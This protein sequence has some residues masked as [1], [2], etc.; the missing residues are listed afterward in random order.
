MT[1]EEIRRKTTGFLNLGFIGLVVSVLL[2][3]KLKFPGRELILNIVLYALAVLF[4]FNILILIVEYCT[5]L[6]RMHGQQIVGKSYEFTCLFKGDDGTLSDTVRYSIRN[7]SFS[8]QRTVYNDSAGFEE[9]TNFSPTYHIES[10]STLPDGEIVVIGEQNPITLTKIEDYA[11]DI[12]IH[13]GMWGLVLAPPLLPFESLVFVRH[14]VDEKVASRAF[15][16]EGTYFIFR[17]RIPF[18]VLSIAIHAPPGYHFEG[19]TATVDTDSGKNVIFASHRGQFHVVNR[20]TV[21]WKVLY[22]NPSLRYK[23]HFSLVDIGRAEKDK[24]C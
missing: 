1:L 20:T 7:F 22:P 17:C 10:R 6:L 14:S 5:F 23:I 8:Q 12:I 2:Y 9:Q 16:K 11:S 21:T 15:S 4:A 19:A 3:D 13:Q 24:R 18:V